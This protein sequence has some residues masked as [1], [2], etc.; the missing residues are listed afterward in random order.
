MPETFVNMAKEEMMARS[1]FLDLREE[2]IKLIVSKSQVI[3][4]FSATT[5]L[6]PKIKMGMVA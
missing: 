6:L 4:K 1:R 5:N 2:W 3:I